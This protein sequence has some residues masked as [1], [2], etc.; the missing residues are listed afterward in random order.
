MALRGLGV[1]LRPEC[2]ALLLPQRFRWLRLNLC[3]QLGL[4]VRYSLSVPLVL[5]FPVRRSI[6]VVRLPLLLPRCQ[7]R[8]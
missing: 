5:G 8:P 4:L 2:P 6:P 3:S 1:Q 7:Y